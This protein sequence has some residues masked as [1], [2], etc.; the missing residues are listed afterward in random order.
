MAKGKQ[1]GYIGRISNSGAQKVEA[2]HALVKKGK[3]SVKKDADKS[4]KKPG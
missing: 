2:P 4:G 3:A 1:N